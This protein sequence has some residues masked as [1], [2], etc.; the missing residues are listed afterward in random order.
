MVEGAGCAPGFSVI[1]E[2]QPNVT[3]DSGGGTNNATAVGP[4]ERADN[5]GFM[6]LIP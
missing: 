6:I 2:R 1:T 4:A 5:V 3:V